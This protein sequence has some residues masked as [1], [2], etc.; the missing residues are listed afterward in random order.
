MDMEGESSIKMKK[1]IILASVLVVSVITAFVLSL[2]LQTENIQIARILITGGHGGYLN[3]PCILE[4]T[5]DGELKATTGI[6]SI[7]KEDGALNSE[8]YFSGDRKTESIKLTKK[9]MREI[10]SLIDEINFSCDSENHYA[11]YAADALIVYALIE[12]TEYITLYENAWAN[13]EV[14]ILAHKL[15]ELSPTDVMGAH[16]EE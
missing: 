6:V 1:V 7:E 9:T 11:L 8:K 16:N 2:S 13:E 4:V 14:A 12:G 5:S 15:V 10:E 3:L